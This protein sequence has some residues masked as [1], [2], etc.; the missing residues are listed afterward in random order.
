MIFRLSDENNG[1]ALTSRYVVFN[2]TKASD[3]STS[4][5]L[6]L[7]AFIFYVCQYLVI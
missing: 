6:E 4:A 2:R 1:T 5:D 7:Y 3:S